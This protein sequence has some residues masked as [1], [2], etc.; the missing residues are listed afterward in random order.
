MLMTQ[1]YL[2]ATGNVSPT[3]SQCLLS[4]NDD[5]RIIKLSMLTNN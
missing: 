3:Y 2:V 5:R 1:H 4:L